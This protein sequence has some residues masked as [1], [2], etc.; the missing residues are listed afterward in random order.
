MAAEKTSNLGLTIYPDI[1]GVYQR[2][3]R[4]SYANNFK[5]IDEAVPKLESAL[6]EY[7]DQ[8]LGVIENGSY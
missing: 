4:E 2:D 8:Q 3:L 6:K 7:V 5:L 1:T